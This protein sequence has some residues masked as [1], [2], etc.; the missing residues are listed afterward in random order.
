MLS[1][2]SNKVTCSIHIYSCYNTGKVGFI[3]TPLLLATASQSVHQNRISLI[4]TKNSHSSDMSWR[5]CHFN[6]I[7]VY[8]ALCYQSLWDVCHDCVHHISSRDRLPNR[9][10]AYGVNYF[11]VFTP[12]NPRLR[13][14]K[15]NLTD[16]SNCKER[17]ELHLLCS[18]K[19]A[20]EEWNDLSHP[21]WS[22]LL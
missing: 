19:S 22:I 14:I 17:K 15:T 11:N 6:V 1:S 13:P 10:K 8:Q 2:K 4:H 9:T 12:E 21:S 3:N 7:V 16:S 20:S 5:S 18:L